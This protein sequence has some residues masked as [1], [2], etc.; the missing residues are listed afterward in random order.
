MPEHLQ[1][2][3]TIEDRRTPEHKA[4]HPFRA[5][6]VC[7]WRAVP[8]RRRTEAEARYRDH[9]TSRTDRYTD[10]VVTNKAGWRQPTPPD[11][12]PEELR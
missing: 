1:H 4:R 5:V 8:T 2:R 12:L 11:E 7:G 6:C 10:R 3:L 9:L